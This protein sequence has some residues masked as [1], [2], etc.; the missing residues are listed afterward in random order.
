MKSWR[1]TLSGAVASGA[2]LVLTLASAGVAEPKWLIVTAGFIAAGGIA[3]LGISGK[4]ASV[5][6]TPE[7]VKASGISQGKAGGQ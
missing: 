4:D 2:A 3:S 1:T 6:S 5:H 7:E